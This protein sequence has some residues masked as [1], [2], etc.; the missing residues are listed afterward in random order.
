MSDVRFVIKTKD[1]KVYYGD[2]AIEENGWL[3]FSFRTSKG[4]TVTKK[5]A[6]ELIDSYD[7][8]EKHWEKAPDQTIN[9]QPDG[10]ITP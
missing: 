8:Y 6:M 4:Y 2:T 3:C 9:L 5:I 10:P 1:G 7:R